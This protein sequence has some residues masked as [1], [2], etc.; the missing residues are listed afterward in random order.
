M[1]SSLKKFGIALVVLVTVVFLYESGKD[2]PIHWYETYNNRDKNPYGLYILDRE[3]A[4]L[5]GQDSIARFTTSVYDFLSGT[6]YDTL[7]PTNLIILTEKSGDLDSYTADYLKD[8]I[9]A[10]NTALI[11]Q[12]TYDEL[13]LKAF[14]LEENYV[15]RSGF[16]EQEPDTRLEL[17]NDHLTKQRFTVRNETYSHEFNILDSLKSHIEILGYKT[18]QDTIKQVDVVRY[19]LGEG[20]LILGFDPIIFTNY[21]ILQSNNHLY[22]E[23]LFSYIP[24]QKT[25]F[26]GRSMDQSQE[27]RSLLRFIFANDSLKWGWYFFLIGLFVFTLFTA[28]RKQRIIPIIKP[29]KNTTVQFTKTVANLYIQSKDYRD[30]MEKS[31]VYT[32]EQIRR[33]YYLDTAVLDED[34]THYYHLKSN[35]NKEDIRAFV[36][37]ANNFKKQQGE[38][39]EADL[40][41]LHRLTEKILD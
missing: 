31:L 38:V 9:E 37:F 34:F 15:Y 39:T 11:F 6:E 12:P 20:Q 2:K 33:K 7:Q 25:Y 13:F 21:Y 35:K 8:Y 41:R 4:H 5:V 40:V 29:V 26:Y 23:A 36:Q 22:T 32:L 14:G 18:I 30:L 19:H 1:N 28:K 24:D 3:L 17:I 16:D 27:S 10:G